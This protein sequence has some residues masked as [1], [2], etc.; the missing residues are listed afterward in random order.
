MKKNTSKFIEKMKNINDEKQLQSVNFDKVT[1]VIEYLD[2][3]LGNY[4]SLDPKINSLYTSNGSKRY[5][6]INGEIIVSPNNQKRFEL[7]IKDTPNSRM[8]KA[9]KI[10][11]R[12]D[13]TDRW[14]KKDKYLSV[15]NF[16]KIM[17]QFIE[18]KEKETQQ[19]VLQR[20]KKELKDFGKIKYDIYEKTSNIEMYLNIGEL[21]TKK[22]EIKQ[23]KLTEEQIKAIKNLGMNIN[24]KDIEIKYLN[25][26]DVS[27]K[28]KWSDFN[29]IIKPDGTKNEELQDLYHKDIRFIIG[30]LPEN[31]GKSFMSFK[32]LD[33]KEII[34]IKKDLEY[35]QRKIKTILEKTTG[36]KMTTADYLKNNKKIEIINRITQQEEKYLINTYN[37]PIN[38]IKQ[39]INLILD[40]IAPELKTENK[41]TEKMNIELN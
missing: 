11:F 37:I 25:N 5:N 35:I 1:E 34:P 23:G 19:K 29:E 13:I 8:L 39:T 6:Y 40:K 26:G 28:Y 12:D 21:I 10:K 18:I 7:I 36:T 4:V 27:V 3:E 30:I 16:T 2:K 9:G 14:N 33:K 17:K 20:L 15:E 24:D 38:E 31:I 32:E 22:M 41:I